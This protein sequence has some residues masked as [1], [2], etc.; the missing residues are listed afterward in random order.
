MERHELM[1]LLA[2][3][4]TASRAAPAALVGGGEAGPGTELTSP[5]TPVL[6]RRQLSA[7]TARG[8]RSSAGASVS[9]PLT[10]P[11]APTLPSP[12]A[13]RIGLAYTVS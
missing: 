3:D 12:G 8:I 5:E 13:P 4:D 10:D 2:G 7:G 1:R 11:P 9:H 6:G